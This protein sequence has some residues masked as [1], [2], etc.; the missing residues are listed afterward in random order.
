MGTGDVEGNGR[1]GALTEIFLRL[2]IR[3]SCIFWA[4][5]LPTFYSATSVGQFNAEQKAH[6][7]RGGAQVG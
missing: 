2:A 7:H 3:F 6:D 1:R 5:R 4:M